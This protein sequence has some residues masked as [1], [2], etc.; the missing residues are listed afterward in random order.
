MADF[1]DANLLR[2]LLKA[3][4]MTG[5]LPMHPNPSAS[6]TAATL[7]CRAAFPGAGR[8]DG[9]LAVGLAESVPS[10]T[11]V[12]LPACER[13]LVA[14]AGPPDCDGAEGQGPRIPL[15]SVVRFKARVCR[16]VA[17]L[18]LNTALTPGNLIYSASTALASFTGV[19][20]HGSVTNTLV[21][22][23]FVFPVEFL[24]AAP[25]LS[26][27]VFVAGNFSTANSVGGSHEQV[28]MQLDDG[29]TRTLSNTCNIS[30]PAWSRT[31]AYRATC[32]VLPG[33]LDYR[34]VLRYLPPRPAEWVVL[35][36]ALAS[37]RVTDKWESLEVENLDAT[38]PTSMV[39]YCNT[40]FVPQSSSVISDEGRDARAVSDGTRP[41]DESTS[42]VA[43]TSYDDVIIDP[44]LAAFAPLNGG[45]SAGPRYSDMHDAH[46]LLEHAVNEA[47]DS[48]KQGPPPSAGTRDNQASSVPLFRAAHDA[49][50]GRS[51]AG[52]ALHAA[53][54]AHRMSLRM[55]VIGSKP[56]STLSWH[57]RSVVARPVLSPPTGLPALS[58]SFHR[59]SARF[60]SL[61]ESPFRR[62]VARPGIS[63][64]G[65]CYPALPPSPAHDAVPPALR[66]ETRPTGRPVV[67]T[68]IEGNGYAGRT[69]SPNRRRM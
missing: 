60:V 53:A 27:R 68:G 6:E 17:R 25:G 51:G 13:S 48:A 61:S 23:S 32:L 57:A 36:D 7:L 62:Q 63:G 66:L 9:L 22:V 12:E 52:A 10:F 16:L 15:E 30:D 46:A 35:P 31:M 3:D 29:H 43:S 33:L 1:T 26:T 64:G 41:R 54:L 4:A 65:V 39:S 28:E 50:D 24:R 42:S 56:S 19:E 59:A 67:P 34:F 49:L 45:G 69:R 21:P 20:A 8:F 38:N 37:V 58:D 47:S 40:V 5:I 18:N 55:K 2:L 44:L 14:S 11:N